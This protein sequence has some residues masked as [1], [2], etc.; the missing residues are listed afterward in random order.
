MEDRSPCGDGNPRGVVQEDKVQVKKQL[1]V[2]TMLMGVIA[3]VGSV[4][5]SAQETSK[6]T[7]PFQ[8]IVGET[9]LPA[10]SYVV[11]NVAY[12]SDIVSIQSADGKALVTALVQTTDASSDKSDAVFSFRKIGGQYFLAGLSIPGSNA[13]TLSLP[14]QRVEAMLV[15]LNGAKVHAGPAL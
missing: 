11:T 4:R 9:V 14:K 10:G 13:R 1:L 3:L 12:R 7:V 5:A 6:V 8:F 2:A 15:K